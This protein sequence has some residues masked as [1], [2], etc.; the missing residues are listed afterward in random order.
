MKNNHLVG[1]DIGTHSIKMVITDVTYKLRPQII[2]AIEITSHGFRYGYVVDKEKAINS[3]A[4]LL[5]KAKKEYP[6]KITKAYFSIA[7]IGL[8]SQYVRT[9]IENIKETSEITDHHVY[10]VIQKSEDLFVA[11]YPNKKILHIIPVKYRVDERDVLGTPIGMYGTDLEVKVIFI[12]IPE[13]HYNAFLSVI[14]K[15][16]IQIIDIIAG[17][18]ADVTGSTSYKQQ[19]QGCVLVN[20]GSDTTSIST[21][22]NN[23]IT[24]LAI[25]SIGSND[26]TN[27]IA[28]G[29]QIALKTADAIKYGEN[30]NYPKRKIEE[31]I[32]A[33]IFDILELVEQHLQKMRKNR[34]LPAGI[35]F[36][37]G[38]SHIE[39]IN[40]YAKK[41]LKLPSEIVNISY[42]SKKT[43]RNIN[44][45]SNQFSIAYGLLCMSEN[46]YKKPSSQI[47]SF[48]KMRQFIIDLFRQITP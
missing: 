47:F 45:I 19:N 16:N 34:L 15:N 25:L 5:E 8:S 28:L 29:L 18:L 31:I 46:E 23:I 35:I 38:G 32:A 33:R 44:K 14:E 26:I 17:P 9:S 1:I 4:L 40:D 12:T 41:E 42:L 36:T 48:K 11:K 13:H 30:S 22:E 43:K 20:I 7:G 3:L 21:F 39:H 2:H 6:E 24:S 37:G 27:D 10:E